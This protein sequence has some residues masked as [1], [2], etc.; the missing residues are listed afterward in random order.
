M[1]NYELTA[2]GWIFM[3]A[4]CG[5]MVIWTAWCYYRVVTMP[6]ATE[7][8]EAPPLDINTHDRET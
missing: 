5:S 4:S 2:A 7:D 8:T 6:P 1:S 3:L